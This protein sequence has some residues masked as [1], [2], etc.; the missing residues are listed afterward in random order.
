MIRE[1]WQERPTRE[2]AILAGGGVLL[3]GMVVYLAL[4]PILQE[5]RRLRSEI[6]AL[7]ADVAWM[8]EHLAEVKRLKARR[9]GRP[10]GTESAPTPARV[11][12]SLQQAGLAY[13]LEA[14]EPTD[15]PG[16]RVILSEAPFPRLVEWL[17]HLREGGARIRFARLR[18][19]ET[20]SGRVRAELTVIGGEAG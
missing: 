14:L 7:R 8:R 18:R 19:A 9:K 10:S 15:H 6:P 16:V 4:E 1:W 13:H 2:R 20:G 5:R 11:Q 3:L 12:E 17:G